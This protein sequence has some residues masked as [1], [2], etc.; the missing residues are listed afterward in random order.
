HVPFI[1]K[2]GYIPGVESVEADSSHDFDVLHYKLYLRPDFNVN[3]LYGITSV[4]LTPEIVN[5]NILT[6]HAQGLTINSVELEGLTLEYIQLEDEFLI[7]LPQSYSIDDTITVD[8]AYTAPNAPDNF[9]GGV[10]FHTSFDLC[11]TFA[12]PY[13]AR[14]WYPCYDLPFDKASSEEIISVPPGYYAPGNGVNTSV[15]E[16]DDSTVYH[17]EENH[18]IATYLISMAASA[19]CLITDES[20]SGVPLYYY[21]YPQDSSDAV[22]DFANTGDMLEFF[23]DTFGAYPFELYGMAEAPIFNGWGAMEH[24]SITTFGNGLITGTREFEDVVIHELAHMWWGDALTPLTFADIW[25]N[26]GFAVY[27]NALYVEARYSFFDD[28]MIGLAEAYFEEDLTGTRIPVYDPPE[29][30]MFSLTIYYKGAWVLHMLRYVMSDDA[31][32]AGLQDYYSQY[33]YGNVTSVEFQAVMEGAYGGELDWFFDEWIYQAGYP[34]YD[35][36]YSYVENGADYLVDIQVEQIQNNAPVFEMPI[37]FRFQG[38]NGDTI[39]T[40]LNDQQSQSYQFNL[41]FLPETC[42]LDP[43]NR[44]LK[45]DN[46][47]G[48]EQKFASQPH[49]I[50]LYQNYPNPFNSSTIISFEL[51]DAGL[52]KLIVYNALGKEVRTLVDGWYPSGY[53]QVVFD[54]KGLSSS[55][56][57]LNLEADGFSKTKKMILLK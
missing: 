53:H 13:C 6:L 43:D 8:I 25:L 54:G 11:Y 21:V 30:M 49:T 27:S 26:E 40:L 47:V 28:F 42:V 39:L 18:P 57:F 14:K 44:I 9:D 24:Q 45:W 19:Y 36:S 7:Y 10:R 52:V 15:I 4:T 38:T 1:D 2:Q 31:F 32:F 50:K 41:P 16:Y 55:S 12:E 56:Y 23:S 34:V 5:F 20:P 17:W 3:L 37:E 46:V 22:Y 51:H 29:S 33:Q 48:V 35:Y